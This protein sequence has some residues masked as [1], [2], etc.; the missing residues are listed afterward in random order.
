[1]RTLFESGLDLPNG[2]RIGVVVLDRDS[3][4]RPVDVNAAGSRAVEA[5]RS[6]LTPAWTRPEVRRL[7]A[8]SAEAGGRRGFPDAG[9]GRDS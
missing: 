5:V 1:M 9:Y 4:A 7:E 6:V 2:L 3:G 8:G